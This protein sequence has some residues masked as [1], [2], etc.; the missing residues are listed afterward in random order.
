MNAVKNVMSK[1]VMDCSPIFVRGK[2]FLYIITEIKKKVIDITIK[3]NMDPY[4]K[5]ARAKLG[6][7]RYVNAVEFILNC[8]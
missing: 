5:E 4:D 8:Q 7:S 3:E 1:L 6:V 2:N